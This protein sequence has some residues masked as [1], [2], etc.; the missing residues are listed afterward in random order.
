MGK[1]QVG[2]LQPME[3]IVT[4]LLSEIVAIP[5]QNNDIPLMNSILSVLVLTSIAVIISVIVLKSIKLR[6]IFEGKPQVVIK[7][8]R[9]D[10]QQLRKLRLTLDDILGA[11]RQKSI[12]NISEVKYAV[13]E[14]NG[15]LSVMLNSENKPLTPKDLNLEVKEAKLDCPVIIDGKQ[16]DAFFAECSMD[17]D[18]LTD[19]L[20]DNKLK[21]DSVY[22]LTVNSS[23]IITLVEKDE[24][25]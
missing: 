21:A 10:N 14:T 23:G 2:E 7:N 5:M 3:L 17:K 11:L 6:N 12:F 15:S 19:L 16:S 20:K 13:V 9:P 24:N 22:L 8:G 1:R 18:K 25:K 4:I